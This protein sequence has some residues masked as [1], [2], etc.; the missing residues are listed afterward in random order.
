MNHPT[1]D[2]FWKARNVRNFVTNVKPAILVVGGLFDAEDCFGAWKTYE[3]I[4]Q[5]SAG[6]NNR[7]G[8]GAV[9]SW[10][11]GK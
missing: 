8:N 11:M 9:V 6:T 2:D 5:K 3:A 7:V 10:S 1:Y 4:E